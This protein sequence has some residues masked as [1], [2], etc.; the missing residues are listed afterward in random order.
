MEKPPVNSIDDVEK[1]RSDVEESGKKLA[2]DDKNINNAGSCLI[3][4]HRR[5]SACA[6]YADRR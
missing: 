1:L 5:A 4:F 2:V 6:S 3:M